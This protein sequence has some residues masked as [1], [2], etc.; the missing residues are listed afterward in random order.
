MN[1]FPFFRIRFLPGF[2]AFLLAGVVVMP[3]F[4]QTQIAFIAGPR[5]H[6]SGDHEFNAG[7]HLLADRLNAQDDVNIDAF[8]VHAPA[9]AQDE[10]TRARVAAAEAVIIYADSTKG[11]ANQWDFFDAYAA[12]GGGLMFMHYAVHPSAEQGEKYFRPWIGG[13]F[14]TGASVNPHWVA[15]FRVQPDHE[16]SRGVPE[17]VYSYDEWYFNIVFPE[18]PA[19]SSV[20]HLG[21]A[22]PTPQRIKRVINLWTAAGAD[23]VGSPVTLMW[24][25]EREGGGRGAGFT[26]GHYHRNWAI[27]GFRTAVLNTIVWTAGLEVPQGG[28]KSKPVT[29]DELNTNLDSYGDKPNP[30]IPLPDI[31]EF[32]RLPPDATLEARTAKERQKQG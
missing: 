29:E 15:D 8:V 18:G 24:G 5:S 4:A 3:A 7:C 31:E 1:C 6:A 10:A 17:V 32:K 12:A 22:T 25:F 16:V 27:D 11:I 20:R 19:A 30:R 2:F 23:L 28:V 9:W 21:T 26:G 13:A 14:E